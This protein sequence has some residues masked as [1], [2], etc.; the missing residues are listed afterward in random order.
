MLNQ[1]KNKSKNS[2]KNLK[3]KKDIEDAKNDKIKQ[4]LRI[5]GGLFLSKITKNTTSLIENIAKTQKT[6]LRNQLNKKHI[7][8]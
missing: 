2:R 3:N 7:K 1:K 8:S 6:Y 5:T 4:S